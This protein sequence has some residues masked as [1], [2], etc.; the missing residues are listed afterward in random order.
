LCDDLQINFPVPY[1]TNYCSGGLNAI[2]EPKNGIGFL[3]FILE[4]YNEG[5]KFP[6]G[7]NQLKVSCPYKGCENEFN[8]HTV[9]PKKYAVRC[10]TCLELIYFEEGWL[11]DRV[12]NET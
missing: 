11:L 9:I 6:L 10:P 4:K 5:F 12:K 1:L 8:M 3:R 2:G 7:W